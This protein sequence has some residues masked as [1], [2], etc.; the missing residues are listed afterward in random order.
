MIAQWLAAVRKEADPGELGMILIHNGIVRGTSKQGTPVSG[1]DLSYDE[2]KLR[3]LVDE[4]KAKDGIV[5][6]KVWI[7]QGRLQVGDDIMRVLVAGRFRT[8]VVPVFESLLST[9]KGKIVR[10]RELG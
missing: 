10:E 6:I 9:I 3:R 8:D 2:E 5:D 4:Q 7:N 1:M